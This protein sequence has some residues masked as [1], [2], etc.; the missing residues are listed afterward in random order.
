MAFIN[1]PTT[2]LLSTVMCEIC[3]VILQAICS[4][5]KLITASMHVKCT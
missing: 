5:W 1:T 4:C 3:A 2:K